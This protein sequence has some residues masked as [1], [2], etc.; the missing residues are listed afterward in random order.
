M[1]M[2]R[3]S[4]RVETIDRPTDSI[5]G[6]NV[7]Q[8]NG[9][10]GALIMGQTAAVCGVSNTYSPGILIEDDHPVFE[11]RAAYDHLPRDVH[12]EEGPDASIPSVENVSACFHSSCHSIRTRKVG[13]G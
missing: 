10:S 9:V 8:G 3:R 5:A 11:E 7:Q 12:I 6:G 2:R 1:C 4:N 13:P